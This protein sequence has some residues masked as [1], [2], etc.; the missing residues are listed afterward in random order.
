M[1]S[2]EENALIREL[3]N[4]VKDVRHDEYEKILSLKGFKKFEINA[5]LENINTQ[6]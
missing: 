1:I 6:K 5:I 2:L 3:P 4:F